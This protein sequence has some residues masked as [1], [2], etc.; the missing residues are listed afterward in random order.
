MRFATRRVLPAVSIAL[1]LT[2]VAAWAQTSQA[3]S[4]P[5]VAPS[6]GAIQGQPQVPNPRPTPTLPPHALPDLVGVSIQF[7]VTE[8]TTWGDGKPCQ[9]YSVVPKIKNQGLRDA[10]RFKVQLQRKKNSGNY[11]EY[12]EACEACTYDLA[13]GLA[14]GRS[15]T[16]DARAANNCSDNDWNWWRIVV[17][18]GGRVYEG[19]NGEANNATIEKEYKPTLLR[20]V[21]PIALPKP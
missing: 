19:I 9:H 7:T 6:P 15:K 13:S 1:L 2:S 17:D 18:S 8:R 20:P 5:G 3:P 21:T 4:G 16:L 10:G 11:W 14:A 12:V